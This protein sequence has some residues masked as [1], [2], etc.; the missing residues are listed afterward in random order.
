MAD[1]KEGAAPPAPERQL[2]IEEEERAM[3][4]GGWKLPLWLGLF[5]VGVIGGITWFVMQGSEVEEV[6]TAAGQLNR[7]HTEHFV[8]FYGCA[9]VPHEMRVYKTMDDVTRRMAKVAWGSEKRYATYLRTKCI[10]Q[11]GDYGSKVAAMETPQGMRSE[12]ND[13]AAKIRDL[14]SAWDEYVR[15]LDRP[16]DP[17]LSGEDL[18]AQH[19][20]HAVPVAKALA[21][22]TLSRNKVAKVVKEL[23]GQ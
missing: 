19:I 12:V 21:A 23:R 11:F 4:T 6:E 22:Y 1:E 7:L 8:A 3:H 9:K 5:A 10:P 2:S 14:R 20:D 15:Y 18:E 13:L 16:M 17:D